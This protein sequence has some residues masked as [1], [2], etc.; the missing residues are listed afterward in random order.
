MTADWFPKTESAISAV[1]LAATQ[2]SR[3]FP[4]TSAETPK[5]LLPIAG[6]PCIIRLMDALKLISHVIICVAEDDKATFSVL[7]EIATKTSDTT[8]E[9]KAGQKITLLRL[10]ENN[11]GSA[12]AIRKIEE[13]KL[14]AESSHLVV[15]PGDLVVLNQ[16]AI[17]PFLRPPLSGS[18][19]SACSAVLV[20]VGEQDE[21]GLPLKESAKVCLILSYCM[22][23]FSM[24]IGSV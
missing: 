23:I 16:N 20:D 22:L 18:D 8:L 19:Q 6:V 2:G 4:L 12:D 5:H 14:V 24:S 1:V 3:L 9:T 7:E 10:P 15:V 21:H 17:E 11:S 13:E